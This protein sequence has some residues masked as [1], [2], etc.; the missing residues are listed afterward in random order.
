MSE[1]SASDTD[2]SATKYGDQLEGREW[3][4]RRRDSGAEKSASIPSAGMSLEVIHVHDPDQDHG[5]GR[6]KYELHISPPIENRDG[7][8]FVLYATTHRWKGNYW[9]EDGEEDW[10]DLPGLVKAKVVETLPVESPSQLDP[11]HRIIG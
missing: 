8:W 9:R 3:A 6:R 2:R 1:Q 11:G 10:Q 5:F 7:Q 4:E